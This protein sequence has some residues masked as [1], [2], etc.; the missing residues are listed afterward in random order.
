MIATD[1]VR[2]LIQKAKI[3]SNTRIILADLEK[4]IPTDLLLDS[5]D[6]LTLKL[7]ELYRVYGLK[8]SQP[9]NPD[10]E[11]NKSREHYDISMDLDALLFEQN[12]LLYAEILEALG[13]QRAGVPKGS[14]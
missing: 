6:K 9:T 4:V 12:M 1:K 7:R 14:T 3:I 11:Y 13:Y 2:T 8:P 5:N 10:S